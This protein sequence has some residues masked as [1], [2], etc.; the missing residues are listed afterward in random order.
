MDRQGSGITKH[1]SFWV[2]PLGGA[3][4]GGLA[5]FVLLHPY[6]MFLV[7]VGA[8]PGHS[9]PLSPVDW[10]LQAI[11]ALEYAM[12]PMAAPL[13]LFGVAFGFMAGAYL[14]RA[15]KVQQ[16]LLEQEKGA[17][18]L[19]TV[20]AFTDTLSHYLLNANMIIGGQVRHCRR[21]DPDREIIESLRVIE[22]QGRVIDAA[23]GALREVARITILRESPGQVPMIDL[24]RELESRLRQV[25]EAA[26]PRKTSESG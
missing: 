6:V 17:T 5:G 25:G 14:N 15:R 19:E 23:V 22:E 2:R 12:L 7:S 24:V 8:I 11:L 18:A 9:S 20:R 16:L 3:L 10:S 4:A 1:R 26:P 13:A 21:F